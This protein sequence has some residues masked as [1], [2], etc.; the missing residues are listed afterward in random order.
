MNRGDSRNKDDLIAHYSAVRL[1]GSKMLR[2]VGKLEDKC[3]KLTE[4]RLPH[5]GKKAPKCYEYLGQVLAYADIIGSCTFGCPGPTPEAHAVL[6]LVARASS[7]GRAALRLAKMAF[8]DEALNIVR[9]IGEIANL[10][11]LFAFDPNAIDEWRKS[12]R[13]YRLEHLS[14]AKIR[15]RLLALGQTPAMTEDTYRNLCEISTHPI[16]ELR[17]QQFNHG[18][19]SMTGGVY[20]Q[21]AGFLVVLNELAITASLLVAFATIVCNV[22]KSA[23]QEIGGA[24]AMCAKSAGGVTLASVGQVLK[25]QTP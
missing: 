23:A 17:P 18:G 1:N 11:E 7:F 21:E 6:Y 2:A 5:M 12:D 24:C 9:S 19:R 4:K 15:R 20:V 16:P 8:Y 10:F 3:G 13:A 25:P 14:P 22:P